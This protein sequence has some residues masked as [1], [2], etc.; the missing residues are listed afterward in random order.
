MSVCLRERIEKVLE[1]LYP[2]KKRKKEKLQQSIHR[3][4][5]LTKKIFGSGL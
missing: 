5:A 4:E 1:G 2:P 3:L